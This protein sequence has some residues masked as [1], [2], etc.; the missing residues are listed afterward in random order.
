[1]KKRRLLFLIT[2]LVYGSFTTTVYADAPFKPVTVADLTIPDN[3]CNVRDYGAEATGIWY[4]TSAFQAAIDDCAEQGGGT[5][6]VPKGNYLTQPLFLKDN[7]NFH[8]AAGAVLQAS[9][10][11]SAYRPTTENATWLRA[12]DVPEEQLPNHWLAFINIADAKNVAITGQG[13]ID[14]Q[15]ATLLERFRAETRAQ[16][17][18]GPTN[19]PRLLFFKDSHNIIVEGVTIQNSPSFHIVFYNVEHL[20]LIH[21]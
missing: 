7:I 11:E 4:D 16:G 17:K 2:A 14:G 3:T 9:A 19:R 20:S 6:M 8:L 21:I 18:K 10:E 5:V 1:M 13:I 12:Y 15:G